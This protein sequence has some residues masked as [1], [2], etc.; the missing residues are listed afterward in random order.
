MGPDGPNQVEVLDLGVVR[1]KLDIR[2][3]KWYSRTM[4]HGKGSKKR[5]FS[6]LGRALV[7]PAAW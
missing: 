3:V 7:P 5:F 2:Q 6:P 4:S 1:I